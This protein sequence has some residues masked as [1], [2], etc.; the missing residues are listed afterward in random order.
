M[1]MNNLQQNR[2]NIETKKAYLSGLFADGLWVEQ[3]LRLFRNK[4]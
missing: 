4:V 1:K 2:I 3:S